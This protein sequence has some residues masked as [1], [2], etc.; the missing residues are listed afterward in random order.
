MA[1]TIVIPLAT[2]D[3]YLRDKGY[4]CYRISHYDDPPGARRHYY[5]CPNRGLPRMNFPEAGGWVLER[6]F[7]KIKAAIGIHEEDESC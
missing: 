1:R 6:H 7:E 4:F 2:V 5:E 3:E